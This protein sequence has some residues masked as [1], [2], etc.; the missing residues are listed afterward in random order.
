MM[1]HPMLKRIWAALLLALLLAARS[2]QVAH[3]YTED[4]LHFAAFCEDLVPDNGVSEG[5]SERC[6][7]DDFCFF[8]FLEALPADSEFRDCGLVVLRSE[9][10]LCGCREEDPLVVL[11]APPGA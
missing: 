1:H 3:I 7:V 2:G 10:T 6:I 5:F 9:A 4:P 11:R 8:P